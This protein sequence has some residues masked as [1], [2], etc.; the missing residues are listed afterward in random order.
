MTRVMRQVDHV[1]GSSAGSLVVE[2]G[3]YGCRH[4]RQVSR[5]IERVEK[6]LCDGIGFAFRHFR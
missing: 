6:E 4:S 1:R 2:Y 5:D 3:D